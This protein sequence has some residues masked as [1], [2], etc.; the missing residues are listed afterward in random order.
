MKVLTDL[1]SIENDTFLST[2][3]YAKTKLSNLKILN[4]LIRWWFLDEYKYREK[5]FTN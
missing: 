2:N 3:L 5:W 4:L 1:D